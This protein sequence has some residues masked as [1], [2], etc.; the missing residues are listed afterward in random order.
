MA[1]TT[2]GKDLTLAAVAVGGEVAASMLALPKM[3]ILK[4]LRPKQNSFY[5]V[6]DGDELDLVGIIERFHGMEF[7][8]GELE[9]A[10]TFGQLFDVVVNKRRLRGDD[11]DPRVTWNELVEIVVN[12]SGH[13]APVDRDTTFIAS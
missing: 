3:L 5:L 4:Y 7:M 11:F 12:F 6:G 1:W 8:P 13:Q 2:A 9:N 10:V